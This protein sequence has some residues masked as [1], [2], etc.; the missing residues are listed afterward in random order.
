M[1]LMVWYCD[2]KDSKVVIVPA[3]AIKG[4][5]DWDNGAHFNSSSLA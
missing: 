1:I 3:P 2:F 4:E 5:G